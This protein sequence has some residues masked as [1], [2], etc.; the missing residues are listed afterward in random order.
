MKSKASR[1]N[2]VV[3]SESDKTIFFPKKEKKI[4]LTWDGL[5]TSYDSDLH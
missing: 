4:R 3:R 5:E 2:S 1:G